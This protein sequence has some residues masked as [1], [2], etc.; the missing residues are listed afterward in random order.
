MSPSGDFS[1]LKSYVVA[2]MMRDPTDDPDAILAEFIFGY[3]GS[4][5]CAIRSFELCAACG[6]GFVCFQHSLR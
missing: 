4:V 2:R 1:T 6:V 3:Y 5:V